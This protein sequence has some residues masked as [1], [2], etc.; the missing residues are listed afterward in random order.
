[1]AV[2]LP[3]QFLQRMEQL[4]GEEYDAFLQSYEQSPRAGLRVNTLKISN[5]Q[6]QS[7]SPFELRP[8]PWCETGYYLNAEER[9]GKHPYYYSGLYYIQEPS[10]M[11]PVEALQ[12]EPGDRVLDL[13]AA[14]GGKSTQIAAALQGQGLLVTNDL[15]ADRIRAL[16]KN[17]ELSGVRNA[18]V[19]NETPD[20]IADRFEGFF[21]KIL[22]DAPCSGEGMF[23]KDEDAA[24]QW[25]NHSVESCSMMQRDILRTVARM[26]A[27]GGRIVYSTCTFAPEEN[28]RSIAVFLDQHPEFQ[29]TVPAGSEHFQPGQS[30]WAVQVE[31][32]LAEGRSVLNKMAA[33]EQPPSAEAIA[34]T[35]RTV[36][37]WP[38]HIEGEGHYLAVLDHT[39]ERSRERSIAIT[40]AET[41]DVEASA[42]NKAGDGQATERMRR[43]KSGHAGKEPKGAQG[44][45]TNENHDRRSAAKGSKPHG[46][47]DKKGQSARTATKPVNG[48]E[49][50][51]LAWTS[52]QQQELN[53]QLQDAS[54]A[55]PR[56]MIVYGSNLYVSPLDEQRLH[57][58][59]V[60]RPGWYL[61]TF[62]NG[63]FTASH[64][65]ATA[66]VPSEAKRRL[67]LALDS[68]ESIAYL[69]GQTLSIAADRIECDPDVTAKGYV[70]VCIDGYSVGWGK[71]QQDGN[72]K[73]EY[74]AGWRWM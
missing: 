26:L 49:E 36:R 12:V 2:Q 47:H 11:S 1:M 30:K 44:G 62:K 43:D 66:L 32:E 29:A 46:K 63:R 8:I 40:S 45:Y 19:L 23:R 5:E 31:Q 61:G 57:G 35:D 65:L 14:P 59:K 18:I 53:M 42:Y 28:E 3:P 27:P 16:G 10:A 15:S 56:Y 34:Q 71:W 72:L 55:D 41:V 37:L 70:L 51:L 22:V 74:P 17:L 39:G 7:K 6:F 13:C 67:N 50:G 68:A 58:L 25:L 33:G 4:L 9:P 38:H 60:I 20:R 73:N 69:K 21:D 48:L 54:S 24:R 64:A 52:F